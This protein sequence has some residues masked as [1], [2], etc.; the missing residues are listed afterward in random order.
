VADIRVIGAGN[1]LMGDDAAGLAVARRLRGSLPPEAEVI[2][3]DSEGSALIE[4]WRAADAAIIIDAVRSGAPPGS[5]HRFDAASAPLPSALFHYSTH[6][7]N[8]ADAVE[9]ARAL[10]TLPPCVVVFGIEGA[11]FEAGAG[12]SAEVERAVEAVAER[13]RQEVSSLVQVEA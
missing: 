7:V 13:V 5:V 8:V 3:C 6:A 10:G 12:L 9:L 4:A 2:D 1:A 11:G